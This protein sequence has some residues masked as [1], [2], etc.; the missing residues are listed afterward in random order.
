MQFHPNCPRLVAVEKDGK[1]ILTGADGNPDC[2][3]G[4]GTPFQLAAR[5][6]GDSIFVDFSPKGGPKD[7]TGVWE[8][9]K[10]PGIRWP[11]GNKWTLLGRPQ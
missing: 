8:A 2:P 9:G 6:D 7:L 4:N 5:V 3:T 10:T 1:A 11:D